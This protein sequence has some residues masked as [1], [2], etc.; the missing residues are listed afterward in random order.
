MSEKKRID[1]CLS[2]HDG[3]LFIEELDAVDIVR[4]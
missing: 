3:H 2:T 4:Q 1:D